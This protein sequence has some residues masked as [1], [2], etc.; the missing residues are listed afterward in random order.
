MTRQKS[1]HII[2]LFSLNETQ[3]RALFLLISY[4]VV[5]CVVFYLSIKSFLLE[6]SPTVTTV[7]AQT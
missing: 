5:K 4:F 6:D 1:F 7:S 2:K 3:D